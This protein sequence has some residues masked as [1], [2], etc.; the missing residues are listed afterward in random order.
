MPPAHECF[1]IAALY[2]STEALEG[3]KDQRKYRYQL[4]V[5]L[6]KSLISKP[7][8]CPRS[9]T[10]VGGWGGRDGSQLLFFLLGVSKSPRLHLGGHK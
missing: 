9:H 4:T 8:F 5:L 7:I 10:R 6:D 2:V 3:Q 1:S